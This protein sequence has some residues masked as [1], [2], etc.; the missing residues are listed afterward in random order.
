MKLDPEERI[1]A[2]APDAAELEDA[3]E[4]GAEARIEFKPEGHAKNNDYDFTPTGRSSKSAEFDDL[5]P[6]RGSAEACGSWRIRHTP[7][8]SPA[9]PLSALAPSADVKGEC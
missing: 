5:R 4:R 8:T 3:N 9:A 2:A 1:I 7:P 6:V